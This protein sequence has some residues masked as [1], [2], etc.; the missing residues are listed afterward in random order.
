MKRLHLLLVAALSVSLAAAACAV[1]IDDDEGPACEE[2]TYYCGRDD[3]GMFGEAFNPPVCCPMG[4]TCCGHES[5]DWFVIDCCA[6][7]LR[8]SDWDGCTL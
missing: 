4:S 8:C 3:T 6:A 7:S 5:G 2:G 1:E